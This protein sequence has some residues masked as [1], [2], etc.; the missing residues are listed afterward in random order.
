MKFI[1]LT[2]GNSK[3]PVLI[4]IK[5]I[6]YVDKLQNSSDGNSVVNARQSYNSNRSFYV[7]ETVEQIAEMLGGARK[8]TS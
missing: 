5:K 3:S 8:V 6:I 2:L 7:V 1:Q 4:K